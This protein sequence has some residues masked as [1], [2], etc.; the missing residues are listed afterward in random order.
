[1]SITQS[2]Q[3]EGFIEPKFESLQRAF[4]AL[5]TEHGETGAA[6]A[7][8]QNK[9]WLHICMAQTNLLMARGIKAIECALCLAAKGHWPYVFYC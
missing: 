5:F 7:V 9:S 1:M 4:N 6:V 8:Y 2:L 3:L